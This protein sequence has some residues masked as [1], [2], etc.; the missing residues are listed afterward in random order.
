MDAVPTW[1]WLLGVAFLAASAFCSGTE[2]ALTALGEPRARQLRETGGRRARLL[3]LWI[4]HPE[5]VLSTLLI[6][7]TLV[8]VGAGALA[9]SVGAD[10]AGGGGW[11]PGTL[12]AIATGV[13]TVVILFA[14]EIVPKTIGKRHPAPVALWAMPMVQALCLAMW[15]LSAAVTRLTGWV[16]GRLG[17]GRAPTPAVTSEEIE[18]LIEMG[19][20]E[21]VLDEVKEELLNSVLEFADRVAKEVMIPR[22]RMVAVDR[23]VEPDELV[24]IVTEN[25]YSRMPVYEGSIDNVVGILLVRDIIQELRHGPLRRIALDRYLKPAFFVPE[26]MKISRLLKEMQRRRT[27]LAVVVDEFGGTSGLVTMEDVIEE[28]VGE[29]QDE[30][31]VESAPVKAV[32]PGVWLADAAIPLHDLQS[33]LNE[34]REEPAP[35]PAGDDAPEPE[36]GEP[37]PEIRFPEQGDYETLGGFVTATAGRVPP[38]GA[39][40]AWDGLTF[41]VRAGDE[42]RVTRVEIARR[43]EVAAPEVAP[44]A[45]RS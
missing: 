43:G 33:F 38:V 32:A 41:T 14:G 20:R 17:G 22:T 19:T 37:P 21:G 10:L 12:V 39:T 7:N 1:K 27:H 6:G 40:L 15:P 13:T 31:D 36:D 3:G 34:Q 5:R 25:P 9:G 24:R 23:A 29:I 44:A 42:R 11:A 30:A 16:V 2:T 8:N 26:Q 28:I 45:A 35:R 18:Y 4:D